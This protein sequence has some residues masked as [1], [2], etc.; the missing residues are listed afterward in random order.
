MRKIFFAGLI[1]LLVVAGCTDE[2]PRDPNDI[3]PLGEENE[4]LPSEET[5]DK[6]PNNTQPDGPNEDIPPIEEPP[7][8]EIPPEDDEPVEP[9]ED[10]DP[11]LVAH[12]KFDEED[13]ETILDSANNYNGRIIGEVARVDGKEGKALLF[14]GSSGYVDLAEASSAVGN[15]SEG[16]IT[17]WINFESTLDEQWIMPI[18]HIGTDDESD[19]D[20]M[21]IIEIGH[22]D[23]ESM[24][25]VLNPSDKKLYVTWIKDNQEPFLCFDSKNN[26]EENKWHH[27]AVV[28]NSSGNTGYL[29]GQEM[30]NRNYNFGN[31]SNTSFLDKIKEKELFALGYGKTSYMISPN[32]IYYKGYIDDVRIYNEPLSSAEIEE[33]ASS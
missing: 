23:P 14:D 21:F 30:T 4:Q 20:N 31:S 25:H 27:I 33:L 32:F 29:N 12:W 18:F 9:Q 6:Q 17:F 24:G 10:I 16:T 11:R 13:G 8:E 28:V 19:P 1:A 3:V 5:G 2:K 22:S 15:L 7:P 26:L